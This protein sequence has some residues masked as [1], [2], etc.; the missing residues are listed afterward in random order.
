MHHLIC[1]AWSIGVFMRELVTC[2]NSFTTETSPSLPALPV[3]YVDFAVW[4]RNE[5]TGAPLQKQLEYWRHKL[6]GA[7]AVITLP[8]DRPRPPV[9]S[10]HG[11]RVPLSMPKEI[12][13][14][15]KTVAR[16]ERASLFMVLMT[17]FQSLLSCL[18]NEEDIVVGSPV[19]GRNRREIEPLIGYFVNTL[20]LRADLSGNPTFRESVR[21]TR[22]SALG[23][24]ANQDVPF[25]K[26]VEDLN[27]TRTAAYNPLF[28]VWF[29]MQQPVAG[30][31]E[32]NGLAM[33]YLDSGAT[34]TRHDLQLSLWESARGL[35]GAVTFSTALFD[36]E[37][38]DCMAEQFKSLVRLI[39]AQPE[40]CL[41]VLRDSVNETGRAYRAQVVAGLEEASLLKLKSVKRK[42]VIDVAPN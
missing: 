13:E 36:R 1:D 8:T 27:P 28:Q 17:A 41:S 35:E 25:E 14:E 18:S 15:L 16:S 6:A 31:Q 11:A 38:I 33:Q 4:Q 29:V 10:F 30:R 21:R 34:L 9:R 32:L 22:E 42:V 3:Q 7:P 37:T 40:T 23:A 12:S 24:F 19:A 26:L 2:Y 39:V 20:V 5:L